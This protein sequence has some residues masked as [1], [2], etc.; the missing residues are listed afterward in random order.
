MGKWAAVISIGVLIMAGLIYYL[1]EK[2]DYDFDPS[3]KE[4]EI[5]Q[6]WNLPNVL[7]EISAQEWVGNNTLATVQD[8]DGVIYYYDLEASE[9]VR[10]LKFGEAGDYEGLTQDDT[11]FWAIES[12][13]TLYKFEKAESGEIEAEQVKLDFESGNDIE[14]LTYRDGKLLISVKNKNLVKDDETNKSIY[15]YDPNS[16]LMETNPVMK[17][18]YNDPAFQVLHESNPDQYIRP[19]DIAI[20]PRTG[21]IYVLDAEVP[22]LLILEND[23]KIKKLYQLDPAEFF[24]PEGICFSDSGRVF[25]SNEGKGGDPK[26]Y[27][28]KLN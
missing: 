5:V 21:E 13:G 22:K 9:I 28:V 20:H 24:Q 10:E 12:N 4:Y 16:N 25:I 14:G 27:E 19:S 8:E 2:Q 11:H 18:N 1:Y 3:L 7:D 23:G 26:L 15:A 17:I 6:K